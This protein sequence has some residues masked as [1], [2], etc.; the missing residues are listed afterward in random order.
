MEAP[1]ELTTTTTTRPGNPPSAYLSEG[2]GT[3]PPGD[4]CTRTFTEA[5]IIQ[6]SQ[7]A[8]TA[9]LPAVC[10]QEVDKAGV[11]HAR[12]MIPVGNTVS[13][14]K[15]AKRKRKYAKCGHQSQKTKTDQSRAAPLCVPTAASGGSVSLCCHQHPAPP[16]AVVTDIPGGY[17]ER[18]TAVWTRISLTVNE[19]SHV[20][21]PDDVQMDQ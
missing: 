14:I 6:C 5:P 13:L 19:V 21:W 15:Y 20:P 11:G 3:A 7:D 1:R 10:Q 18:F 4:S 8:K 2:N 16:V 9:K 12:V 17:R